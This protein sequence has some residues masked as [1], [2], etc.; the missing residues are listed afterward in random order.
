MSGTREAQQ[1][2]T[3]ILSAMI[4]GDEG[5]FVRLGDIAEVRDELVRLRGCIKE[6]ANKYAITE[7][8]IDAGGPGLDPHVHEDNDELIYVLEGP[9]DVL[10]GEDWTALEKGGL[11]IIPAKTMHA[12]RN[13]SSS[14]VGLLNVFLNGSYEAMMPQIQ[15]MFAKR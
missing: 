5:Q 3:Q 15:M 9:V 1:Q 2:V 7:W 6:V 8:W 11:V 13:T 4:Y 10:V 14:R 12:F